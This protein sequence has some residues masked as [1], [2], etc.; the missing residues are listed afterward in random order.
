MMFTMC[1]IVK[2]MWYKFTYPI[3]TC[4]IHKMYSIKLL[5]YGIVFL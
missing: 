5:F 1:G 2:F 3:P 4:I